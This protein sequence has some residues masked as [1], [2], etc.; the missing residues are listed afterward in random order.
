[1]PMRSDRV[2]R[3]GRRRFAGRGITQREHEVEW[4]RIGRA[5]FAHVLGRMVGDGQ[6]GM[7]DQARQILDASKVGYREGGTGILALIDAE[8]TYNQLQSDYQNAVVDAAV[9]HARLEW[10]T[11]SMSPELLARLNPETG[12]GK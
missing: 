9:A 11:G 2:S 1:M 5:E 10:A 3:P 12:G 7:L 6:T 8:R 4:R